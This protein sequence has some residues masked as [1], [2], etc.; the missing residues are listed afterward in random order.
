MDSDGTRDARGTHANPVPRPA[1]PPD[2]PSAPPRPA[3]APGVPPLPDG[4]AGVPPKPGRDPRPASTVAVWLDTARPAARPGIWRFAHQP[5]K[6]EPEALRPVTIAGMLIPLAVAALIWSLWQRGVTTFQM[7]P[8]RAF[9]P[10]EWWGG[11]TVMSPKEL[12]GEAVPFPGAEA[13]VVYEGISFAPLAIAAAV[14]GSWRAL[15]RRSVGRRP[16]P[17]RAPLAALPALGARAV[18]LPAACPFVGWEAVPRV[19][20]LLSFTV[21]PTNSYDPVPAPF[22]TSTLC[23]ALV[24]LV[25][26][27]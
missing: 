10:D 1:G 17:A 24:L 18:G 25:V 11:G 16:Q 12:P 26:G 9:T 13:L 6:R 21:L 14:L 7:A 4:S 27:P 8:L 2:M 3:R 22:F 20:P 19:G 5:P 15:V 23:T